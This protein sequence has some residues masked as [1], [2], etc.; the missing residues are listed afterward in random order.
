MLLKADEIT[1]AFLFVSS[2]LSSIFCLF[3]SAISLGES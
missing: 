1:T 3:L 2:A